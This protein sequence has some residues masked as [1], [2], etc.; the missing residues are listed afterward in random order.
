MGQELSVGICRIQI[1][2]SLIGFKNQGQPSHDGMRL[3]LQL[4]GL[5]ESRDGCLGRIALTVNGLAEAGPPPENSASCS[6]QQQPGHQNAKSNDGC[7]PPTAI[8]VHAFLRCNQSVLALK[9][10]SSRSY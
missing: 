7:V 8:Y 10:L 5:L 3:G 9:L 2:L 6:E 1:G 4:C